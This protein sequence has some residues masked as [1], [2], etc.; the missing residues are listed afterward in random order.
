MKTLRILAQDQSEEEYRT[1][2][3]YTINVQSY[4]LKHKVLV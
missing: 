2:T 3:S 4:T 1:N